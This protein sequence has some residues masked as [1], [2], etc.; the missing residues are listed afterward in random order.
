LNK[1][2]DLNKQILDE[3]IKTLNNIDKNSINVIIIK[4][5]EKTFLQEEEI[6]KM[7]ELTKI[8]KENYN[9]DGNIIFKKIEFFPIPIIAVLDGFISR[10]F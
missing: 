9:K 3:L 2:N 10:L 4:N 1:V 7:N 8:Q 6:N 5:F